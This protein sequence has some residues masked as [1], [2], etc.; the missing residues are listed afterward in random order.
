MK[1]IL[2][3][4]S[5]AIIAGAGNAQ[6]STSDKINTQFINIPN[7]DVSATDLS[8]LKSYFAIGNS[9]YGANRLKDG[10]SLCVANG[11]SI[12]DA[13]EITTYYYEHDVNRPDV[14]LLMKDASGNTIYASQ[15]APASIEKVDYGKDQCEFWMKASLEKKYKAEKTTWETKNHASFVA[16]MKK[17][18]NLELTRNGVVSYVP[19]ELDLYSAKGKGLDYSKMEEAFKKAEGAYKSIANS[20]LSQKSYDDLGAAIAL[21]EEEI[22]EADLDNKDARI[23]KKIAQGIYINLANAY[24]LRNDIVNAAIYTQKADESFGNF[25]SNKRTEI[26][27]FRLDV[28]QR[29][30]GVEKNSAL[31]QDIAKLHGMAQN[32][33][34]LPLLVYSGTNEEAKNEYVKFSGNQVSAAGAAA[35]EANLAAGGTSYDKY[36]VPNS[37]PKTLSIMKLQETL[38]EF[39]ASITTIPGLAVVSIAANNIETVSDQIGNMESLKKLT[40]S[41]NKITVMPES[42]GNCSNL[43]NL[44]LSGNPIERL[45]QSIK[46]CKKLKSINLK[47][48]NV[49]ADHV[50]E[51]QGW[52]P[53]CKIKI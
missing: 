53:K 27:A 3:L 35:E 7:Y 46:N 39:P 22:K 28:N 31:V 43:T 6:K 24:F 16:D 37:V 13:K 1:K 14:Y 18:T 36:V 48:T 47:N 32:S 25:T 41:K 26:Q 2:L 45:P 38:T 23:N 49:S 10:K 5:C 52:L 51:I 33:S 40:L 34:N 11:G 29:K 15:V 44:N 20:G 50:Q 8:T 17:K 12:K 9:A 19:F 42:I 4:A 21:W 30:A